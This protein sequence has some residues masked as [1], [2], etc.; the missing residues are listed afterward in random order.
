[1][2]V[3][4]V[5]AC[6]ALARYRSCLVPLTLRPRM[7]QAKEISLLGLSFPFPSFVIKLQAARDYLLNDNKRKLSFRCKNAGALSLTFFRERWRREPRTWVDQ[8]DDPNDNSPQQIRKR[9]HEQILVV[10]LK[11]TCVESA[12]GAS[13]HRVDLCGNHQV[14]TPT[15]GPCRRIHNQAAD[16][17]PVPIRCWS[18]LQDSQ[19]LCVC[20][21]P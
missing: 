4:I 11:T 5:I 16:K 7:A 12:Q 10:T 14:S 8:S 2:S 13:F 21:A 17:C 18:A 15:D 6:C 3:C 19:A 20:S 9:G 1:M